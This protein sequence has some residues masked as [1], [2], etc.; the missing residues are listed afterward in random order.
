MYRLIASYL[1]SLFLI[2]SLVGCA[3]QVSLD[4]RPPT[5]STALQDTGSRIS[6]IKT[7]KLSKPVTV[8]GKMIEKCPLAGCWFVMRDE[9][10]TIKVD[11]KAAG[12]TVVEVPL[13]TEVTITGKVV[14]D[15][16]ARKIQAT[17]I[18]Y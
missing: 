4:G 1:G 6:T 17:A 11:T 15:G 13:Q 3:Q 14:P 12:F 2:G 18:R 16:A 10:G 8:K 9:T 5:Q 7:V